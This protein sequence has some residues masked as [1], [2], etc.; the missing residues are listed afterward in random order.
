MSVFIN[1]RRADTRHV[2]GRLRDLMVARFGEEHV[3][4]DVEVLQPGSDYINAID[5]Y[6]SGCEVM[7][8]LIGDQW[9]TV[10]SEAGSR[11][12]DDPTD[13]LRL[14]VEAGLRHRTRVIP[15]LVDDATMPE[16][17][18]LPTSLVT[19]SRHHS[20]RLR[21]ETFRADA[22]HLSQVI[23]RID[24]DPARSD[25]NEG[26][27]SEAPRSAPSAL[28]VAG[29]ATLVLLAAALLVLIAY[30]GDVQEAVHSGRRN[31]PDDVA[32]GGLLWLVPAVPICLAGLLLVFRRR[33]AGIALGCMLSAAVWVATE[34]R[35]V[36]AAPDGF[37]VQSAQFLLLV[38]VLGAATALVVARP[39]LR[40][41][42]GPNRPD[43][44][45]TV[46]VLAVL[47]LGLRICALRIG[48]AA[49]GV[50]ADLGDNLDADAAIWI[51]VLTLA[52]ICLPA[53]FLRL[54]QQQV[55]ALLTIAV[56][57]PVYLLVVRTMTYQEAIKLPRKATGVIVTDVVILCSWACVI[58][59]VLISQRRSR[60]VPSPDP[61]PR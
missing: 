19:L 54:R 9:L 18:D 55:A 34:M 42:V 22:K 60:T 31:L 17:S 40:A 27:T 56:L 33:S 36:A 58:L 47:A 12:L 1:Y 20:A 8:V 26:G 29:W 10:R 25:A 37:G 35:L 53:A 14:E 23:S 61:V 52:V 39:S 48:Q 21:H 49:K 30:K 24:D 32:S 4:M 38:L 28:R 15:V 13:R 51:Y 43:R 16:A 2:A 44:A 50:P 11:R 41:R 7:L 45:V 59:A 5:G 46:L 3:F 57:Q 6:V